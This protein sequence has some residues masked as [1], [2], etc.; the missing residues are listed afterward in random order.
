MTI[1]TGACVQ[2]GTGLAGTAASLAGDI[3]SVVAGFAATAVGTALDAA[4]PFAGADADIGVA[5]VDVGS[6]GGGVRYAG[7][8]PK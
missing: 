1:V 7:V 4:W 5:V 2:C 3:A 8:V 6:S